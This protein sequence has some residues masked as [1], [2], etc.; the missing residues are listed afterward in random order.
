MKTATDALGAAALLAVVMTLGDYLWALLHLPHRTAYGIT[1]GA[2]MCLFFG[3]IVGW[4]MGRV[5]Q[6]ALAGPI[7]GVI[8]ALVFYALEPLLRY[9]A[10]LP[11][12]MSFWI[13]FAFLQQRLSGAESAGRAALRGIV[14]AVLSGVAFYAISGIWTHGSTDPNYLVNLGSWIIAFLP[15]FLVLFYGSDRGL[16]PV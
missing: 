7:I 1:H 12:W 13:M 5:P 3:L 16:T 14:A 6:G 8:S 15:G 10:V 9:A 11:A 4:R 2:V